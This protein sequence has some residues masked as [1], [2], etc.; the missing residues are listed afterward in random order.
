MRYDLNMLVQIGNSW[1]G[2]LEA[3]GK[4]D[5]SWGVRVELCN[6]RIRYVA[7]KGISHMDVESSMEQ[8]MLTF[9]HY[10]YLTACAPELILF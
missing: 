9:I 4:V 8:F 7:R 10:I 3:C 2:T 5:R 1:I 6:N